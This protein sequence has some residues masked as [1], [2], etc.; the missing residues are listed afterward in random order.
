MAKFRV[1]VQMHTVRDFCQTD[2]DLIQTLRRIADIGYDAVEMSPVGCP[3]E[4]PRLKEELDKAGLTLCSMHLSMQHINERTD[5][6]FGLLRQFDCRHV[7][8]SSHASD[9]DGYRSL[10]AALSRCADILFD[11]GAQFSYHNHSWELE[12]FGDETGLD[13][14]IHHCD[15][16]VN[17]ELDTFWVQAGGG[18]P[19][20]WIEK[21]RGR[22]PFLHAK[23]MTVVDSK[24][25][26]AEVGEGNLNWERIFDAC[27]DVGTEWVIV[28]QDQCLRDP[29][30]SVD[31]SLRNL[32]N[33]G[34]AS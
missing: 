24:T 23:D 14:L 33:M 12:R 3:L 28:E 30:E 17:F 31:T 21:V 19:A 4:P 10:A 2:K 1:G 26:M 29:F 13:I 25:Q 15:E 32:R 20:Q 7:A 9:G 16:K 34:V 6:T 5:E 11:S 8:I 22:A 27:R 18:D